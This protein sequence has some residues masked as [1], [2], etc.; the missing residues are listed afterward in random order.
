ML[1]AA[2]IRMSSKKLSL[3]SILVIAVPILHSVDTKVLHNGKHYLP[4]IPY[5]NSMTCFENALKT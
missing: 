1:D 3:T 4:N 2:M 5:A